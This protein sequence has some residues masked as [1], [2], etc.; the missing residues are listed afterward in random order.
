MKIKIN[1]KVIQRAE[2]GDGLVEKPDYILAVE[3][4]KHYLA[5]AW[6]S[7]R[8]VSRWNILGQIVKF[9]YGELKKELDRYPDLK[10]VYY[11][12]ITNAVLMIFALI[13][14]IVNDAYWTISGQNSDQHREIANFATLAFLVG[15]VF[16][17]TLGLLFFI[18]LRLHLRKR[19]SFKG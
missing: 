8:R 12:I 18:A 11:G 2:G 4:L 14:S 17:V 19:K 6:K 10:A 16:V 13:V 5:T 3:F 1:G 15:L 9:F 7:V